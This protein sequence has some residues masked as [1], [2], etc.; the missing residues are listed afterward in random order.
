MDDEEPQP[1]GNM[2]PIALA[3]LGLVLGGS[4]LY[5]ALSANKE[6][7]GL[8]ASLEDGLSSAARLEKNVGG[9]DTELAELRAQYDEMEKKAGR[10]DSY[11]TQFENALEKVTSEINANR[12]Q[13]IKTAK[14]LNE[15]AARPSLGGT[16]V[17]ATS[18]EGSERED[19]ADTEEE[20]EALDEENQEGERYSI[21][22]GDNFSSIARKHDVSL[23]RLLKANPDKDPSK[24]QIG[25]EI[26]IP[27]AED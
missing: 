16:R 3:L 19:A 23:R 2:A 11:T 26:I 20:E 9:I 22:A 25:D 12:E 15:L 8:N 27:E 1:S 14:N 17:A 7:Q 21:Q 5:F 13:I 18:E 24:L 4:A 6:L 10:L